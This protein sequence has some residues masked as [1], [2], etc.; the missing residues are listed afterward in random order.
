M[1]K[2]EYIFL[3]LYLHL[4]KNLIIF[5]FFYDK[6]IP[7]MAEILT[8]LEL[9]WRR[10]AAGMSSQERIAEIVRLKKH[11]HE[12]QQDLKKALMNNTQI[13]SQL[14][15]IHVTGDYVFF[16]VNLFS[17]WNVTSLFKQKSNEKFYVSDDKYFVFE[18]TMDNS[19]GDTRIPAT[20]DNVGLVGTWNTYNNTIDFYENA[21]VKVTDIPDK[22]WYEKAE[23]AL[24]TDE[25]AKEWHRKEVLAQKGEHTFKSITSKAAQNTFD[26]DTQVPIESFAAWEEK[27]TKRIEFAD[28]VAN[29]LWD[30]EFDL[31]TLMMN[32][33]DLEDVSYAGFTS[34]EQLY[35]FQQQLFKA[36]EHFW[37]FGSETK[38][39]G[40]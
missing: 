15:I 4:Y 31:E 38:L 29:L 1:L 33:L 39:Q 14:R 17:K 37:A 24:E 6:E 25:T 3:A 34:K 30:E 8:T 21:L 16:D 11:I 7:K 9:E 20:L 22:D 27:K 28:N 18:I 2:L 10:Q 13:T 36:A 19:N 35:K 23:L 40:D 5:I 12:T 26:D 32:G